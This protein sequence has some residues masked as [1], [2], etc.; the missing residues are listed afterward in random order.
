MPGTIRTRLL[1]NLCLVLLGALAAS[2]LD[3]VAGN[4]A[5]RAGED[6]HRARRIETRVRPPPDGW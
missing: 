6:V 1:Q 5:A 2:A 4:H 3:L